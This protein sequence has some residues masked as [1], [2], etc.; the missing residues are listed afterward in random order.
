LWNRCGL[1]GDGD[2]VWIQIEAC[3]FDGNAACASPEIDAAEGVA[4][5]AADIDDVERLGGC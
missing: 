5:A 4:V 1:G 2:G 3:E